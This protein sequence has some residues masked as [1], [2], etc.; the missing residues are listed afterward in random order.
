MLKKSPITLTASLKK[1]QRP[2]PTVQAKNAK[3]RHGRKEFLNLDDHR[4]NFSLVI[5]LMLCTVFS[6]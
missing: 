5:C 3:F 2:N 6:W 1:P 4:V